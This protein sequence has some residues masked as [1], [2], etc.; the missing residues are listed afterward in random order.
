[1]HVLAKIFHT[2]CRF[3]TRGTRRRAHLRRAA[4]RGWATEERKAA[5]LLAARL[6]LLSRQFDT[7][8]NDLRDVQATLDRYFDRSARRVGLA[9]ELV[10]QIAGQARQLSLP[11]PDETLAAIAAAQ[12]GR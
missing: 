7:A 12:A 5:E 10:R 6:A 9:S 11:R 2:S 3:C 1:M 4:C 8:Q